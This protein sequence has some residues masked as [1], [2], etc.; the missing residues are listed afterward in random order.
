M[1]YCHLWYAYAVTKIKEIFCSTEILCGYTPSLHEKLPLG[2]LVAF[3]F[4]AYLCIFFLLKYPH[5][6]SCQYIWISAY[7]LHVL[8]VISF[9]SHLSLFHVTFAAMSWFGQILDRGL[10]H[11]HLE[12]VAQ[13]NEVNYFSFFFYWRFT[14]LCSA[15]TDPLFWY[16]DFKLSSFM[17][18]YKFYY[19]CI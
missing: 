7:Y 6:H 19:F 13:Q 14:R 5:I 10:L 9:L 2:T 1:L 8:L 11:Q 3:M 15:N 16:G 17:C 12:P 4:L 18:L